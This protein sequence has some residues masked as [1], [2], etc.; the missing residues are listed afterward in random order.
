[1]DK[2]AEFRE[3]GRT[4]VVVSHGL[5]QMRTFCDEVAWLDHGRLKAVTE[6]YGE[7][8][9]VPERLKGA[10]IFLSVI[11]VPVA[12]EGVKTTKTKI[13]SAEE[14]PV[15]RGL[16]LT[17]KSSSLWVDT[18]TIGEELN[19]ALAAWLSDRNAHKI[20]MDLK[21]Q[22]KLLHENGYELDVLTSR[23]AA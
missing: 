3:D 2:F 4:V 17:S 11:D 7:G 14:N 15:L 23:Q 22:R 10:V 21:I 18:V 19:S 5:E 16:I 6:G 8:L 12:R 20:V 9:D 13:R 1:M